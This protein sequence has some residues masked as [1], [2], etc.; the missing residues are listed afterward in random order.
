MHPTDVRRNFRQP[1]PALPSLEEFK[2]MLR[3]TGWN[4]QKVEPDYEYAIQAF[5]KTKEAEAELFEI[6]WTGGDPYMTV[7]A[8]HLHEWM[9]DNLERAK[10]I[11]SR[12]EY[13]AALLYRCEDEELKAY[14]LRLVNAD[15]AYSFSDDASVY[16]RGRAETEEL[17]RIANEKGGRWLAAFK[18]ASKY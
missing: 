6:A 13:A 9:H 3:K 14:A 12:E 15:W 2:A 8:N 1:A 16:R 5:V 4:H 17:E 11:R 7:W 10:Q 18:A